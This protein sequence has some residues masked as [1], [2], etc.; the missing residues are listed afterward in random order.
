MPALGD[1]ALADAVLRDSALGSAPG[2]CGHCLLNALH[3][4]YQIYNILIL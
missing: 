3:T 4:Y 1:S 2:F